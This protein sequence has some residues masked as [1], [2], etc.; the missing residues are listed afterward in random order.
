MAR[1][2]GLGVVPALQ[3]HCLGC[4]TRGGTEARYYAQQ[5]SYEAGQQRPPAAAQRAQHYP[6]LSPHEEAA[7]WWGPSTSKRC[8]RNANGF[9]G[10]LP[11]D[12]AVRSH[13]HPRPT[14]LLINCAAGI[15]RCIAA[16]Q[17][18]SRKFVATSSPVAVEAR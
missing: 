15:T 5:G 7:G 12:V 13:Y 16:R 17:A 18:V 4:Q 14:P 8:S 11:F 9:D 6:Y 10:C 1:L 2:D 3:A